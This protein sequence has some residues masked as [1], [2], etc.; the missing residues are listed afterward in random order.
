MTTQ[1]TTEQILETLPQFTGSEQLYK[2]W[3]QI[4]YS[5]GVKYLAEV[6]QAYWLIDAIASHY[7]TKRKL[8]AEPFLVVRLEVDRKPGAK[9]MARLTFHTD[10]DKGNPKAYPSIQTQ[11]ITYTDFPLDALKFYLIDGVLMLPSEY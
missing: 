3:M 7:V 2:H 5:D 8:R 9:F 10:W 4:R 11:R 6:A 1:H